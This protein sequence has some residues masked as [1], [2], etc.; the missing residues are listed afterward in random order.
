M[1]LN[2]VQEAFGLGDP[3]W[4]RRNAASAILTTLTFRRCRQT[5]DIIKSIKLED[6]ELS[7]VNQAQ[8]YA[9]QA[10]NNLTNVVFQNPFGFSLR[11]L[12]AGGTFVIDRKSVV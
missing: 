6:L 1:A 12:A 11:A 9:P 2:G 10:K 5:F 4:V 3:S 7:I 8:A